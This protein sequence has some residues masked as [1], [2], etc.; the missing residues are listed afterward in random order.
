[1]DELKE[2]IIKEGIFISDDRIN[3]SG[4]INHQIDTSLME[5]IGEEFHFLFSDKKVDKILTVEASGIAIS[6]FTARYFNH[7]PLVFAKKSLPNTMNE[8]FYSSE[9][10]SFTKGIVN[11]IIVSKKYISEGENILIIDD[12]LANGEAA[13][14]LIRII[15]DAK[16][17]VSGIGIVISKNYQKGY[18][19]LKERGYDVKV[20]APIKS[21]TNGVIEWD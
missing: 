16:A 6:S 3:V 7:C 17:K 1:M 10:K 15:E 18:Y 19:N 21:I 20:L 14:A 12:F 13:N 5:R 4:F 11:N 2:R 9:A 8:E